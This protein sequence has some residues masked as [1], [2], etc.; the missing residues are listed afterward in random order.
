MLPLSV[1]RM[2]AMALALALAT[3]GAAQE[4]CDN[5]SDDDGNG[6]V[7]LNDTAQCSCTAPS[8]TPNPTIDE[9]DC[10]PTGFSQMSCVGSWGQGTGTSTDYWHTDSD[11]YADQGGGLPAPP[12][13]G[14]F[15]G[16]YAW[17]SSNLN[18]YY[19]EYVATC[20]A[21]PLLAGETYSLTFNM[22]AVQ[23]GHPPGVAVLSV[24]PMEPSPI[25]FT[26]FGLANCVPFPLMT[27][28]SDCPMGWE[29]LGSVTYTPAWDWSTVTLSFTPSTDIE[30][31]MFGVSCGPLPP[32]YGPPY[33]SHYPYFLLDDLVLAPG[34]LVQEGGWCTDDLVLIAEPPP[35]SVGLQWYQEGVALVGQTADTLE[36]ASLGL[37]PAHYQVRFRFPGGDCRLLGLDVVPPVM[38]E[39]TPVVGD[40]EGC[41]PH[42]TQLTGQVTNVQGA[43][44]T[45]ELEDGTVLTG[46]GIE[47]VFAE[48]GTYDILLSVVSEDGCV[49]DTLLEDA[50]LVHPALVASFNSDPELICVGQE[51]RFINTP[52]PGVRTDCTWNFGDGG[53]AAGCEVVHVFDQPGSH[54]VLLT[55]RSP[56]GCVV[57][58]L[59]PGMVEVLALP[60]ASF[61]AEPA[62]GCVPLAVSFINTSSLGTSGSGASWDLGNGAQ[63]SSYDISTT[64][65]APGSYSVVLGMANTLGCGTEYTDTIVVHPRPQVLFSMDAD[66]VCA[67]RPVLF[68]NVTGAEFV[69]ECLWDLGNGDTSS[70]CAMTHAYAVPGIYEVRLTITSPMGCT[71]DTTMGAR[72]VVHPVPDAAFSY[73]PSAPDILDP[74]VGFSDRSSRD[75]SE[76]A[77]SFG[78]DGVLGIS[79]VS[80][81]TVAFPHIPGEYPVM[82]IVNNEHCTDTARSILTIVDILDVHVPNAFTPDG[83]ELNE[84]FRPVINAGS[85]DAYE[86]SVFDRWGAEVFRT[87]D[88][89]KGWDGT[90]MGHPPVIGVY[91]WQLRLKPTMGAWGHYR[92]HVTLLR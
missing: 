50:V 64:Y 81:P 29:T 12:N 92:G 74:V 46:C 15:M 49:T 28:S 89:D 8:W 73:T 3:V 63:G 20:L 59:V 91:V 62:M 48:P 54:D 30:A 9:H 21:T 24:L 42:A 51:V 86:L 35:G 78:A 67:G 53:T 68:N 33:E 71:G 55:I 5:G 27:G 39:P 79:Q 17:G 37:P 26:L 4:L 31:V 1:P 11:L 10:L 65:T 13:G 2:A 80:S 44:C 38:P 43:Q 45:W 22:A 60:Q 47:H 56:E 14:G 82:L 76:W 75:V 90:V 25:G 52:S 7:D 85:I 19:K 32:E 77:W 84:M 16:I 70:E 58:T 23:A 41:A 88:P 66:S 72:V 61:I 57:D 6:L 34:R 83:D 18:S 40:P 36:L 69:E 87:T